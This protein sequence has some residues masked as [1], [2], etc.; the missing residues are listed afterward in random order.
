MFKQKIKACKELKLSRKHFST[1]LALMS[2]IFRCLLIPEKATNWWMSFN[3]CCHLKFSNKYAKILNSKS[4]RFADK[5]LTSKTA[6]NT[7]LC[8]SLVILAT[9]KH[10]ELWLI[11]EQTLLRLSFLKD[12]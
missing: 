11:S 9:S 10:P 3:I 6:T 12:L 2:P 7:H 8:T 5:H 1:F 4:V